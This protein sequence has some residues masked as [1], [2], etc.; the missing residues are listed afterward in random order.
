MRGSWPAPL[1]AR[2]DRSVGLRKQRSQ[3]EFMADQ[4]GQTSN[5]SGS[6]FIFDATAAQYSELKGVD[7]F[8]CVKESVAERQAAIL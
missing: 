3:L 8:C 1:F 5:L 4:V 6:H 2:K 7:I